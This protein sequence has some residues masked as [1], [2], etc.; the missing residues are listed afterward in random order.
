MHEHTGTVENEENT[1]AQLCCA[2]ILPWQSFLEEVAAAQEKALQS[3]AT[4]RQEECRLQQ[5]AAA[6]KRQYEGVILEL[7]AQV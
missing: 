5:E 4:A 2:Q 3:A 6:Q 1:Q 7:Q